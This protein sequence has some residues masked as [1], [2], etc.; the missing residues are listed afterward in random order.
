M[1]RPHTEQKGYCCARSISF[2]WVI[3]RNS[4]LSLNTS[5]VLWCY[6][7]EASKND[8]QKTS[9]V[10]PP[11]Q[12]DYLILEIVPQIGESNLAFTEK[13][14]GR[15]KRPYPPFTGKKLSQIQ[16]LPLTLK[17]LFGYS[18]IGNLFWDLKIFLFKIT[19]G[20][21]Y[22]F[23]LRFFTLL[24]LRGDKRFFL[25]LEQSLNTQSNKPLG[26]W[27]VSWFPDFF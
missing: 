8:K 20:V 14:V 4:I 7:G 3:K 17:I 22:C 10:R 13:E 18:R 27:T 23:L 2:N 25:D 9:Y 5:T 11:P 19:Q 24:R 6:F 1:S 21:K 26:P 16:N 12:N 15:G